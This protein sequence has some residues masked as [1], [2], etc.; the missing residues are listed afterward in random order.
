[1]VE[2]LRDGVLLL[3]FL[4]Q[5][6]LSF[7]REQRPELRLDLTAGGSRDG[8]SVGLPVRQV[9]DHDPAAPRAI[10]SL[11]YRAL[12]VP[13]LPRLT[14]LGGRVGVGVGGYAL[15]RHWFVLVGA[16]SRRS[17]SAGY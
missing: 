3:R 2:V 16:S 17:Q 9:S 4:S 6:P 15:L 7:L 5:S 14:S 13:A 12:S 10:G 11:V 1:A 8:A